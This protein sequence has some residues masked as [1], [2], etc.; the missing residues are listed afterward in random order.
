MK[1]RS[2][3]VTNSS[4]SS[5]IV[6]SDSLTDDQIQS[7][8]NYDKISTEMGIDPDGWDVWEQD[9]KGTKYIYGFTACCNGA[10]PELFRKLNI[11]A[12]FDD[13]EY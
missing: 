5:F 7:I 8:L 9:I 6:R 11:P 12:E 10:M 3:F 4:S 2:D 13:D 1:Y